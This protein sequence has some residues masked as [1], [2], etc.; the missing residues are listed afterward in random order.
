VEIERS[1]LDP[2]AEIAPQKRPFHIVTKFATSV[3]GRLLNQDM[4]TVQILDTKQQLRSFSKSD[5]RAYSF[6]DKPPM[7]SYR[8][9]LTPQELADIIAYLVTLRGPQRLAA[10]Q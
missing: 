8:D 4:F 6:V 7:P 3:D 9:K 10:G 1:L 2:D 5:L